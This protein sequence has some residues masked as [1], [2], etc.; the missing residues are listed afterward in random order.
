MHED[1]NDFKK[2][3]IKEVGRNGQKLKFG[4]KFYYQQQFSLTQLPSHFMSIIEKKEQKM[5]LKK[6]ARC[7]PL[8]RKQII[9]DNLL[10]YP[11]R[12]ALHIFDLEHECWVVNSRVIGHQYEDIYYR[13]RQPDEAASDMSEPEIHEESSDYTS[14]S[15]IDD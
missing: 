1:T 15:E 7:E 8:R 4:D 5:I 13:V 2:S 9:S 6:Q 12:K 14:S 3:Q 11:G 10:V